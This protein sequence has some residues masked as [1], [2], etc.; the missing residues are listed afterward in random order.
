MKLSEIFSDDVALVWQ[1]V[2]K[3]R[4]KRKRVS[5]AAEVEGQ[6]FKFIQGEIMNANLADRKVEVYAYGRMWSIP[7]QPDDDQRYTL[8]KDEQSDFYWV[9]NVE[10]D[11]DL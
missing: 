6:T 3:E 4:A 10:Q 11:E 1:L 8:K 5:M 9:T 7:M 2:A